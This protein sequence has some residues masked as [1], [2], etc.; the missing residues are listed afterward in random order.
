M[1]FGA[2]GCSSECQ[3]GVR[4]YKDKWV[5]QAIKASVVQSIYNKNQKSL[6]LCRS[7]LSVMQAVSS[8]VS[9]EKRHRRHLES[10]LGEAVR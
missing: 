1:R 9:Q 5:S 10:C 3:S 6:L 8:S 4:T 2:E 7:H